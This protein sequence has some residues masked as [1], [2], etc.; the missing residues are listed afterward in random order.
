MFSH[1]VLCYGNA[2]SLVPV[3]GRMEVFAV[4]VV[5][6]FLFV[7]LFAVCLFFVYL[8]VFPESIVL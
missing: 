8:F 7:C 5:A 3:C 4:V 2:G 1:L 6:R